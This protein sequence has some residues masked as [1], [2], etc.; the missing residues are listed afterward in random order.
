MMMKL[1]D[2]HRQTAMHHLADSSRWFMLTPGMHL[3]ACEWYDK[4]E[5]DLS[6]QLL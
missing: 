4:G 1:S 3:S 5:G 2:N 6:D